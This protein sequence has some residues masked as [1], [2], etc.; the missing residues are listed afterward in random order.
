M[1]DETCRTNVTV[2]AAMRVL[3]E[4]RNGAAVVHPPSVGP[5]EVHPEVASASDADGPMCSFASGYRSRWC[6]QNKNGSSVAH[7]T[8]SGIVWSTESVILEAYEAA[9]RTAQ[10]RSGASRRRNRGRRGSGPDR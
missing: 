7:W 9:Y 2:S 6:T 1:V 4:P 8:P 10:W 3:W 5:G